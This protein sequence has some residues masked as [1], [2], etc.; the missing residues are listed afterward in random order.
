MP[1]WTVYK[2]NLI[3][4]SFLAC[5]RIIAWH[6]VLHLFY[7]QLEGEMKQKIVEGLKWVSAVII[8]LGPLALYAHTFGYTISSCHTR[9][10]EFGSAMS[11]IYGPIIAALALYV[12]YVQNKAQMEMHSHQLIQELVAKSHGKIQHHLKLLTDVLS[13]RAPSATA[14]PSNTTPEEQ[15]NTFFKHLTRASLSNPTLKQQA[16]ALHATCPK[17]V[18]NWGGVYAH[19]G[20]FARITDP[21]YGGERLSMELTIFATLSRPM[22]V[23]L[24]NYH[25]LVTQDQ[26]RIPYHFSPL[27]SRG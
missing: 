26:V 19:F 17:I 2:R 23:A 8:L 25:Y 18:E 4:F 9:W 5:L 27:F 7:F 15:L 11:G 16:L 24:D 1:F 12:L 10:S 14:S 21:R 3:L 20:A 22:C 6:T 13:T